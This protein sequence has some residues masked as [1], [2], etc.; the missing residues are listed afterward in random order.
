MRY[1]GGRQD[2]AGIGDEATRY[3]DGL[4]AASAAPCVSS[5]G[6]HVSRRRIVI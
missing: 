6:R 4:L 3:V 1:A 2:G 5:A